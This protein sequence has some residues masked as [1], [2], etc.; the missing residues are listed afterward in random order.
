M[1]EPTI[2]YLQKSTRLTKKYMVTVHGKTIHFGA[3]GYSDYTKHHDYDR[4]KR[5][6]N[7][8]KTTENWN[9]SGIETAGFWAKWILWSKPTLR[10]AI[11]STED[12]FNLRILRSKA[13][14]K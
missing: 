10:E 1:P 13:P 8:H 4:M 7:R 2:V 14:K 3:I 11:E 5:Y 12:K 9:K 6:N